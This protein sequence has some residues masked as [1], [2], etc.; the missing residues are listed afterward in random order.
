MNACVDCVLSIEVSE[1]KNL[2][3]REKSI[4]DS[5]HS[6]VVLIA[7]TCILSILSLNKT[8]NCM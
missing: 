5:I 4:V 7:I 1:T 6:S 2:S 8:S 3:L